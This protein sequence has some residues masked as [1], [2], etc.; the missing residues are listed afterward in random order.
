MSRN[1]L[2]W[3]AGILI[4]IA[5]TLFLSGP[6]LHALHV[7]D[8]QQ[9][10]NKT[11]ATD[12][13]P[14]I[15]MPETFGPDGGPPNAEIGLDWYKTLTMYAKEYPS[16]RPLI[17]KEFADDKITYTEYAKVNQETSKVDTERREEQAHK[18]SAQARQ[19]LKEVL[20]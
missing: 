6:L 12:D 11:V 5:A 18:D 15:I 10:A 17:R 8:E 3:L 7:G 14:T 2:G 16:V 1:T 4:G 13:E 9:Q 19:Q 20:K